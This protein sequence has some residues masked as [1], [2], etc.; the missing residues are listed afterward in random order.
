[1][2]KTEMIVYIVHCCYPD[3]SFAGIVGAFS[4]YKK[5]RVELTSLKATQPDCTFTPTHCGVQ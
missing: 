4:D 2:E 3:G 1:M 5:A